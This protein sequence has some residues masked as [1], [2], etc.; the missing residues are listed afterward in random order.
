MSRDFIGPLVRIEGTLTG[1]K[2]R[3]I[4]EQH[5][6]PTARDR[7]A[8]GWKF[9][10]DGDPKHTCKLMMGNVRKLPG[11]RKLRLPGWFSLNGVQLLKWPAYSPDLNPIE[12][13]W[14]EVKRKLRGRRFKT[15][16]EL[17]TAVQ[18]AWNTIPLS[19]VIKLV[20]SMPDR[21][22]AVILARGGPTKY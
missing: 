8:P 18:Q 10:Q 7:M 13:L 2:Y 9:Q 22:R 20:D 6:L 19:K 1:P 15:Q 3:D 12:H 4:M 17:W 11:G 16:D 14:E 5:M 21:I